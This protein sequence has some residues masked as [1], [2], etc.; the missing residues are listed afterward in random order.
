MKKKKTPPSEHRYPSVERKDRALK[1]RRAEKG[2]EGGADKNCGSGFT[3]AGLSRLEL[4]GI[5]PAHM[6]E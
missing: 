4:G 3:P 2:D 6:G 5:K 1:T